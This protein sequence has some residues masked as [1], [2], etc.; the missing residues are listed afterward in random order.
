VGP[1]FFANQNPV[2]TPSLFTFELYDNKTKTWFSSDPTRNLRHEDHMVTFQITSAA[3][4]YD[5]ASV[6]DY[7][8]AWADRYDLDYDY[9]DFVVQLKGVDHYGTPEP[10]TI[11]IWSLLGAVGIA[12]A[13]WRR[14]KAA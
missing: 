14:R 13:C 5:Q 11:V 1:V 12:T 2:G 7:V 9:N 8:I 3:G 4:G 10:A 6:G